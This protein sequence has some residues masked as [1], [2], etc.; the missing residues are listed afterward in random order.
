M[1]ESKNAII[2]LFSGTGNTLIAAEK[3][4]KALAGNGIQTDLYRIVTKDS[5]LYK[6][7]FFKAGENGSLLACCAED[8]ADH[9]VF[10]SEEFGLVPDPNSYDI[11][12]FAYPIHAF[13]APQFFL[14]FVKKLP[15]LDPEKQ[16]MPAFLFKTS[17]EPFKPNASSSVTLNQFL[18]KK[19]FAPGIDLHMLMPYNIM[20][21]YPKAMAKQMYLHTDEMCEFLAGQVAEGSFQ[22]L[23]YNLFLNLFA[24]ILRIQWFG[25]W[26]NGP[27]HS[28]NK[29]LCVG[30]GICA[31]TCPT[32]N[33]RMISKTLAASA[34][35]EPVSSGRETERMRPK[36]GWK[37]TMCMNCTMGCPKAAINPGFLTPWKVNPKWDFPAL[38]A[39]E[40][41]PSN[42]TDSPKAKYFKFFR[43]YYKK[44]SF[45]DYVIDLTEELF[46][47]EN[48]LQQQVPVMETEESLLFDV[49]TLSGTDL[50][51][52]EVPSDNVLFSE[53]EAYSEENE[54]G[55]GF[56]HP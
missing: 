30:C 2:Y 11:A 35:T 12:G 46:Q 15:K 6:T 14:R 50:F 44:Y 43:K 38:L 13:N 22:P 47:N 34:L 40:S 7:A 26:I 33:I 52:E 25:A 24:Y 20:F 1:S 8:K 41:I 36:F 27:M 56:S 23:H 55:P 54:S 32:N 51:S 39:D 18:R 5:G 10:L 17:G 3:T 9:P 4:A 48:Q 45:E 49:D 53:D 28:A 29:S 21:R 31:N 37:C 16:G 42:W 19:G